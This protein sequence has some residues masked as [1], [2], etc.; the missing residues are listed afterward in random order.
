M[1]KELLE[2]ATGLG[3]EAG[4]FDLGQINYELIFGVIGIA[5][6][7]VVF[8]SLWTWAAGSERYQKYRNKKTGEL[9]Q[10]IS[11]Y[12]QTKQVNRKI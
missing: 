6:C 3:G 2:H 11:N 1:N 4:F 5:I 7:S 10:W 8:I 12:L 9:I